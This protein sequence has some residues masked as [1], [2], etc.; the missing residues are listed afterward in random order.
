MCPGVKKGIDMNLER[1]E[2]CEEY[3][4]V[5]DVESIKKLNIESCYFS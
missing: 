3:F 5:K 1:S 2:R 4:I